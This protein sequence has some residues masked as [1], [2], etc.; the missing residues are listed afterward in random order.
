MPST[1]KTCLIEGEMSQ[2]YCE[3]ERQIIV[4]HIEIAKQAFKQGREAQDAYLARHDMRRCVVDLEVSYC[5]DG[6]DQFYFYDAE[7]RRLDG[8]W[9][10]I[11]SFLF[12]STVDFL[13]AKYDYIQCN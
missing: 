13:S 11:L 8:G 10:G 5:E 12:S 3:E 1:E 4:E 9:E 6:G 2:P 7:N